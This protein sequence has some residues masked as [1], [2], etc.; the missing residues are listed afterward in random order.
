MK[1][2][3]LRHS[4]CEGTGDGIGEN[5]VDCFQRLANMGRVC[6]NWWLVYLQFSGLG[7]EHGTWANTVMKCWFQWLVWPG[8]GG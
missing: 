6:E 5:S 3:H 2:V 1:L 8:L 4:D 7:D